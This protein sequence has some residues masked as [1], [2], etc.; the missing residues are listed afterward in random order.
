[1]KQFNLEA[2]LAGEPVVTSSGEK[3]TQLTKFNFKTSVQLAGVINNCRLCFWNENGMIFKGQVSYDDIFMAKKPKVKKEGWVNIYDDGMSAPWI[4]G[5]IFDS[6]E[7][8][9]KQASENGAFTTT[10]IEWEEE[11]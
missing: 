11:A 9:I 2:A 4:T 1:M 5:V 3:V 8:A 10:K 6:Q 7:K